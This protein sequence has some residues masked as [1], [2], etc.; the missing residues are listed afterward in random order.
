MNTY[1]FITGRSPELSL[2]ELIVVLE[3]LGCIVEVNKRF[4]IFQDTIDAE[5]LLTQLGGSVKVAKVN[6]T[7]D[8][9]TDFTVDSWL[10]VVRAELTDEKKRF[11]FGASVYSHDIKLKK[12]VKKLGLELKKHIRKLSLPVRFVHNNEAI[13]SSVAV[14]KNKLLGRELCILEGEKYYFCTTLGVQDFDSYGKR[15]YGRPSRNMERGMLPPK[16]AQIMLNLAR[17]KPSDRLL[18]PFC[19]GGTIVQEALLRGVSKVWGSDNDPAAIT[20]AENNCSWLAQNFK[21]AKPTLGVVDV[22]KLEENYK[23]ELFDVVV[24]ESYLGPARLLK[25]ASL[26]R[27]AFQEI[28]SELNLLFTHLFEALNVILKP[29]GRVAIIFPIF[30]L[31][32]QQFHSGNLA[33]IERLGWKLIKPKLSTF[34]SDCHLSARGQLMYSR[35]DQVVA[36]E[37]IVW[38][39][40]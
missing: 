8:S 26:T 11:D 9:Y 27:K 18:D 17:V 20:E 12:Y 1:A 14:K 15:D 10:Q 23:G 22:F 13:L 30:R 28:Q 21:A 33:A 2:E 34:L 35:K 36:R 4:L 38:E 29:K 24:T 6:E 25:R 16:V 39:K 32:D 5:S 37:I 7:R 31:F 19:G 40:N 3:P